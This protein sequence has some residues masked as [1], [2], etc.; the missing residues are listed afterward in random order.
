MDSSLVDVIFLYTISFSIYY[1][2][3]SQQCAFGDLWGNVLANHTKHTV[4]E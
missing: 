4:N 3:F 2:N 1:T